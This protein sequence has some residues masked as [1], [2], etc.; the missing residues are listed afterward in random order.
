[1]RTPLLLLAAAFCPLL[2]LAQALIA[3]SYELADGSKGAGQLT[4]QPG[5]HTKL[6]LTDG[7]A[8]PGSKAARKGK[9]ID[10]GKVRSF[11]VG[12]NHYVLVRSMKLGTGM[13]MTMGMTKKDEFAKVLENGKLELFQYDVDY[14]TSSR[15]H[16]MPGVPVMGSGRDY[17]SHTQTVYILRRAGENDAL[18]IPTNP[19]KIQEMMM[20]YFA[21][22]P[23]LQKRL[24]APPTSE[25]EYRALVQAYNAAN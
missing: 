16:P 12:G 24:A 23:D 21:G 11:E 5:Y 18:M 15:S 20:P 2:G 10:A 14:M 6:L 7:A 3:T 9:E 13:P 4:V 1:M 8:E 22:R 17:Q 19:K 25:A